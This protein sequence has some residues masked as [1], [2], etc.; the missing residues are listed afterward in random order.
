MKLMT[1]AVAP[2]Y[3]P[4]EVL[5]LEQVPVPQPKADELLIRVRATTVNRTDCGF[6]SAEYA[7]IRFVGGGLLKPRHPI[8][9]CEYAGEVVAVG[10]RVTRFAP[11]DRVFGFDDA[12]FGSHAEY[13]ISRQTDALARIPDGWTYEEAAPLLEGAHYADCDWRAAGLRAGMRVLVNG[14]TGAIGSA[15]VQLAKQAGAQVTAVC[16]TPHLELV[17][18]LGA[19]QVVDY[20]REDVVAR[21]GTY[22]IV[23]DAVGKRR[24]R[25]FIS[26][27]E[28]DGVYMS[29]ELGPRA[30]NIT[31]ALRGLFTKGKRVLFPIP[32]ISQADAERFAALASSGA[33]RPVI[34]SVRPFREIV[35]ATRHVET[36]MKTG[37]VVLRHD[38]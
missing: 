28:P 1:A 30:E 37:N 16:A 15:A 25:D 2:A 38:P 31:L 4:P 7:I 33:Y 10:D 29:T 35:D 11:G 12:R 3:G 19:D 13:R 9:G 26:V 5:R 23:F 32:T 27:L 17:A 22:H 34:D 18:S 24:F 6:R 8:L 21:G 36:G 14:A 20:T